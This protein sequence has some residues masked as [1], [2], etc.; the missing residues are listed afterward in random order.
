MDKLAHRSRRCAKP[1]LLSRCCSE[2]NWA[3]QPDLLCNSSQKGATHSVQ[4][5]RWVR[6]QS[7]SRN[8]NLAP[9]SNA[10]EPPPST[11]QTNPQEDS[12]RSLPQNLDTV[13]FKAEKG[14]W[15]KEVCKRASRHSQPNSA[16]LLSLRWPSALASRQGK[17]LFAFHLYTMSFDKDWPK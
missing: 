12:K 14:H 10:S 3:C 13:P 16:S 2:D 8:P 7:C 1:F 15:I 17:V 6:T 5:A 4:A 11:S 9:N